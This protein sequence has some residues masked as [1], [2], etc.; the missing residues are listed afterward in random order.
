MRICSLLPSATEIL[1]AIGLGDSV[2]GVT[3]EC[4]FPPDA[5]KKPALI[6]P[7]VDP[8]ATPAEIDRRV[9]EIIARGES[10]YAVD[11]ELLSSLAPDLI[12][13]Q[14]LCHV[15]A[16][17]PDDLATALTRFPQPPQ[18]L[19]LTPRS[20]AEVW[21]D[22]RRV[23]DATGRRRDA[24]V[25]AASLEERVAAIESL[26]AQ[27]TSRPRVLCLEWLD[28]YFVGGHWIP[29]MVWEAGGEDVLGKLRQPSFKVSG[30]EI[31]A[32]QPDVIVIMPC[33]YG[34]ARVAEEFRLDHL[35]RGVEALPAVKARRVFAVDANAYFSRPGPRLADGVA[36]LA[37]I[38]H[39]QL[40]PTATS[41]ACQGLV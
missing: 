23:G 34:T 26:A 20:L 14:D 5:A 24:E 13:T 8:Q 3:H 19:S 41:G 1:Y 29:E 37:H 36:I 32:S 12:L 15:C 38:F 30:E 35:P 39:P 40:F 25:L 28:P 27:A 9:S 4:D 22:I 10:I 33:G 7:R 21:D 31:L 16:A 11:A 18:V 2:L 17:S 6:R